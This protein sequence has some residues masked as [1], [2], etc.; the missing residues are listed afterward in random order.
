MAVVANDQVRRDPPCTVVGDKDSHMFLMWLMS[1]GLIFS[2]TYEILSVLEFAD[3][4]L[5]LGKVYD[6]WRCWVGAAVLV[7]AHVFKAEVLAG[8]L[9]AKKAATGAKAQRMM[10][11]LIFMV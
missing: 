1:V 7:P 3:G 5:E 9:G 6:S 8:V 11:A 10:I 4:T 2:E